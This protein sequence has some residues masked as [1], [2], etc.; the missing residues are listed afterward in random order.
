MKW[1]TV[2]RK[3]FFLQDALVARVHT[4]VEHELERRATETE[5]EDVEAVRSGTW[6]R[7]ASAY[8]SGWLRRHGDEEPDA[9]RE[10]LDPRRLELSGSEAR[11]SA[12]RILDAWCRLSEGRAYE[13]TYRTPGVLYLITPRLR[14]TVPTHEV[15]RIV[16]EAGTE[17]P[18]LMIDMDRAV[19]ILG[20]DSTELSL[21]PGETA[22]GP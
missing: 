10:E 8:V 13:V 14:I 3:H 22:D 4:Q 19:M 6:E 7:A 5:I 12:V 18:S 16:V 11:D 9:Q 21:F 17:S 2:D 1:V 20:L 15:R